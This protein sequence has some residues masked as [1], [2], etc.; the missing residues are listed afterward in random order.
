M[1]SFKLYIFNNKNYILFEVNIGEKK[2]RNGCWGIK[3]DLF[4]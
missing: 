1:N 4:C 3:E 2:R